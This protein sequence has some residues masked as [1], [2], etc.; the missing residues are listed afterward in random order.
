MRFQYRRYIGQLVAVLALLQLQ[1]SLTHLDVQLDDRLR[2]GQ[3]D[4][5]SFLIALSMVSLGILS[6]VILALALRACAQGAHQRQL[7]LLDALILS[8]IPIVAIAYRLVWVATR[9]YLFSTLRHRRL[10]LWLSSSPVPTLWLGLVIGWVARQP[11][12]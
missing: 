9:E 10:F 7:P 2:L 4:T 8:I 12:E 3:F 6:G 5:R 11:R 1:L